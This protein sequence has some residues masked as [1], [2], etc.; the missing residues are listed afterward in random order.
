MYEIIVAELVTKQ[1]Q[2][3]SRR[4]RLF[5]PF[6]LREKSESYI[7]KWQLELQSQTKIYASMK[8]GLGETP[9]AKLDEME[10]HIQMIREEL[11]RVEK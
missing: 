10:Q 4:Q 1:Q 3:L 5:G 7:K 8:Q 2:I 11:D 9:N 6:N